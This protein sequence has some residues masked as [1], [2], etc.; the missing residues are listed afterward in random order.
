[1][2]APGTV[3]NDG[4]AA[5]D[6]AVEQGHDDIAAAILPCRRYLSLSVLLHN[7]VLLQIKNLFKKNEA[8]ISFVELYFLGCF[9]FIRRSAIGRDGAVA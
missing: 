6:I 3:Q 8:I 5:L 4:R 9:V 7:V 2:V 1:M